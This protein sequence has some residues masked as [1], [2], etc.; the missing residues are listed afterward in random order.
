MLCKGEAQMQERLPCKA[1]LPGN[2]EAVQPYAGIPLLNPLD[3]LQFKERAEDE[4]NVG[5]SSVAA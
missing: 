4:T 5:V 1:P 3:V 2:M